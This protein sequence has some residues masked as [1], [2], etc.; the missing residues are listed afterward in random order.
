MLIFFLAVFRYQEYYQKFC[1]CSVNDKETSKE[2]EEEEKVGK[3]MCPSKPSILRKG[4]AQPPTS[5]HFVRDAAYVF[6][7]ALHNLWLKVCREG[8]ENIQECNDESGKYR[9]K[10][11]RGARK[12]RRRRRRSGLFKHKENVEVKNIKF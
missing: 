2:A 9:E 5:A 1:N 11:K 10:G 8:E 6:A 3:R 7:H 4:R 12:R